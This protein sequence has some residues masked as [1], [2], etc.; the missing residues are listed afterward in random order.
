MEQPIAQIAETVVQTLRTL[1][2][3]PTRKLPSSYFRPVLRV[4]A[5]SGAP[6]RSRAGANL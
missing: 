5:S 1:I 3:D 4:R 6:A 2:E